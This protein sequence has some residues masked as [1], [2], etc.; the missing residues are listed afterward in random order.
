MYKK[1]LNNTALILHTVEYKKLA[2]QQHM[3]F[4]P[5]YH[6]KHDISQSLPFSPLLN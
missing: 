6:L 1:H 3:E 2:G 4:H 5:N